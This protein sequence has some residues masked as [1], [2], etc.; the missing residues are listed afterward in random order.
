MLT[1]SACGLLS[2]KC[3]RK[4]RILVQDKYVKCPKDFDEAVLRKTPK[5]PVT[6]GVVVF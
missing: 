1:T 2:L 3:C 6:L 4:V 5:G